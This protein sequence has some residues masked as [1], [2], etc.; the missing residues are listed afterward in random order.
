M[1]P[2][3]TRRELSLMMGSTALFAPAIVRAQADRMRRFEGTTLNM[4]AVQFGHHEPLWNQ[5]AEFEAETGIG[6][7]IEFAPFEGTREKTLLDMSSR[8]GRFDLFTV[9]IMWLA[10]YAAAGYLEPVGK[11]LADPELTAEDYDVDD[12]VPRVYSGTGVYNDTMY[13]VP[14]DCG[15]VGNMF[16]ADLIESAGISVPSRFDGSFTTDRMTEICA[17]LTDASDGIAGYVVGPQRWFWGWMFTPYLYAFQDPAHAG[18]EFVDE[19]WNVTI[20]SDD[21]LAALQYYLGLRDFTPPDDLNFG[22]GEQLAVYQQGRAAG[23]ITYSGFIGSH[24]EDAALPVAGKNV[25]LHTP[26]GPKGR[27]DPFF[28]SWGLSISVDSRNKEAAWLFIQ[29]ITAKRRLTQAA[30]GGAPAVRHSTFQNAAFQAA[31]PWGAELYEY[32]KTTA[33]PDERIRVPEWAEISEIM[34]LYGNKAWGNEISAEQALASMADDMRGA[35][36]R[37]GYYRRGANNP[38]QLWRDLSYYD[39]SP[40]EWN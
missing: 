36:R 8:T 19:E 10:E 33:N 18:N 30:I 12:F 26:I 20:E 39:R 13:N 14:Y 23:S 17:A 28:G 5:I 11:F 16:R 9:D 1:T 34:G 35:F 22:Y 2:K 7:N 24:Y 38:P 6:I 4:L 21:N 37:G 29:W 31:Q 40:S 27:T 15:T 25:A 3:L 32:M